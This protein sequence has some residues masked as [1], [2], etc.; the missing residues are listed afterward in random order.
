MN[1]HNNLGNGI[2]GSGTN[3]FSI[4]NSLVSSN[5]DNAGADEAGIRFDNGNGTIGISNT[6]IGGSVEDNI[7]IVNTSGS[8]TLNISGS[9]I[10]D[11]NTL[12]GND[13]LNLVAN[14]TANITT[15]ITSS[16][17][18]DNFA[19]GVQVITNQSGVAD[20]TINGGSYTGNNIG[21]N[22]ADNSSGSYS[23]DVL[24]LTIGGAAT[25]AGPVNIFAGSLSTGT[26]SGTISGNTITNSNSPTGPGI[27]VTG[28]GSSTLTTA[29]TGNNISQIGHRGIDIEAGQGS[30]TINA[31]V[32]GNTISNTSA[33]ALNGIFVES[34]VL[35]TDTSSM[36]AQIGGSTAALKNNVSVSA[37][38]VADI[39]V[40]Q[41]FAGAFRL[42][43]YAGSSTDDAAVAAF[44]GVNNTVTD[45]VAADH[46]TAGWGGGAACPTP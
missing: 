46:L 14:N 31:T 13:G 22:L 11:N 25:D 41:R 37:A 29:I 26:M 15:S 21:V 8:A 39:R 40:R 32:T 24:N 44:V 1:V 38:G 20:V 17:F 27:G 2:Y 33:L 35:S 28:S 6:N 30:D 34:A 5:G 23:F 42:P 43:G 45:T 3:G 9:T 12:T 10:H 18:T 7:R 4:S 16:N 19:N 36:C